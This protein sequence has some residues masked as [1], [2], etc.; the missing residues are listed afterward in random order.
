MGISSFKH[1]FNNRFEGCR[2]LARARDMHRNRDVL[3][4]LVPGEWE[5]VGVSDGTDV[6]IA[7]IVADPFSVN[8]KQAVEDI[9]NGKQP[10]I[11]DKVSER[12]DSGTPA[13]P[14]HKIE[15]ES[16]TREVLTSRSECIRKAS[17]TRESI[18]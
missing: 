12:P 7:P 3:I 4:Y 18:F 5:V 2:L 6:W 16:L 14:P 1:Y 9:K 10:K 13:A 11:I 8:I 17:L 15:R